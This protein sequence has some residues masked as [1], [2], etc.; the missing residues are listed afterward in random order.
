M[1][2]RRGRRV[3]GAFGQRFAVGAAVACGGAPVRARVRRRSRSAVSV[4]VA[5]SPPAAG[6]G[7]GR[8]GSAPPTRSSAPW[9]V[10]TAGLRQGLAGRRCGLLPQPSSGGGSEAYWCPKRGGHLHHPPE[11]ARDASGAPAGGFLG[12]VAAG[13]LAGALVVGGR[14]VLTDRGGVVGVHD[15]RLAPRGGAHV[16]TQHQHPAQQ[17]TEQPP[18]GVHRDQVPPVRAGVQPAHPHPGRVA[19]TGRRRLGRRRLLTLRA[20]GASRPSRSQARATGAGHAPWPGIRAGS[21][22]RPVGSPVPSRA[23][24]VITRCTST[25]CS[26]PDRPPGQQLQRGVRSDRTHPTTV[27]QLVR[28]LTTDTPPGSGPAAPRTPRPRP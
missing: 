18:P 14:A 9:L 13:A 8:A 10:V 12:L 26:S 21:H 23:R 4:P 6:F 25:G 15:R 20:E 11:P 27:R 3:T 24:S 7:F 19:P 16:V 17:P 22:H 1:R 5:P 2:G 28:A